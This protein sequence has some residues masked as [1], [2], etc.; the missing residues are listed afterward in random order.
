MSLSQ[1]LK[2]LAVGAATGLLACSGAAIA[3]SGNQSWQLVGVNA[4]LDQT[5]NSDSVKQ[6]QAIEARLDGTVTTSDGMKLEKGTELMGTVADAASS[7]HGGPASLTLLFTKAQM[8]DGKQIPV[9]V[10]LLAAYPSSQADSGEYGD[11]LVAP[12]PRHVD[13]QQKVVQQAGMLRHVEMKSSVQG[14]N[15]GTFWKSDG[16]FRLAK[17]TYLQVGIA[18]T[19]DSGPST[20]E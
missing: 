15:S 1:N 20:G 7:A 9:K 5:I 18:A 6:G 3:Q 11:S 12:A 2:Y 19:S 14:Q 4:R 10:T 17:G 13:P 16:N 8:K